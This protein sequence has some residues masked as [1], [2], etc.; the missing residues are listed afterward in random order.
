ME[1]TIVSINVN[2]YVKLFRTRNLRFVGHVAIC[3]AA[4]YLFSC[5]MLENVN[6]KVVLHAQ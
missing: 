6:A 1:I 5:A 2:Q 4:E 3:L